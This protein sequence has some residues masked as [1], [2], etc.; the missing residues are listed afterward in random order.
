[1][2]IGAG[3]GRGEWGGGGEEDGDGGEEGQQMRRTK[4]IQHDN[5]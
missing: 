4:N 1:M 5:E 3:G 2:R